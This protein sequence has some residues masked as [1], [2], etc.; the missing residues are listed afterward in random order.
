MEDVQ[1]HNARISKNICADRCSE[2]AR[3]KLPSSD[4]YLAAAKAMVAA[5]VAHSDEGI[6]P[7]S[8]LSGGVD[9]F[10]KTTGLPA[11]GCS[12]APSPYSCKLIIYHPVPSLNRLFGMNHWQRRRE[13]KATQAAFLSM[14]KASGFD[15]WTTTIC[16]AS[17]SL[18]A[19]ATRSSSRTTRQSSSLRSRLNAKFAKVRSRTRRSR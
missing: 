11:S 13:K 12:T 17:F 4:S 7:S 14:L 16:A 6:P 10:P 15:S 1:K 9:G 8:P 3:R 19:S 2:I 5:P 18:T